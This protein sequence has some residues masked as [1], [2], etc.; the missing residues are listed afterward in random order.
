[1]ASATEGGNGDWESLSRG[2]AQPVVW[3][4]VVEELMIFNMMMMMTMMVMMVVMGMMVAIM[5]VT[6][7]ACWCMDSVL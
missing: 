3:M 4:E 2:E 6:F 5:A 1:M 7:E